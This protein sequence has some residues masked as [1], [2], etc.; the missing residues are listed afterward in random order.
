M[1]SFNKLSLIIILF[2]NV[3]CF[4]TV[5]SIIT[6]N[7]PDQQLLDSWLNAVKNDNKELARMLIGL[8][9]IG[10]I[11]KKDFDSK[12]KSNPML[13]LAIE[14]RLDHIVK[15]LSQVS[16]HEVNVLK[17]GFQVASI[18][19]SALGFHK[20]TAF[21][22]ENDF[23]EINAFLENETMLMCASQFGHENIVKFLL[24]VPGININVQNKRGETALSIAIAEQNSAVEKLIKDKV[25]ELLNL[26]FDAINQDNIQILRAIIAQIGIKNT[27]E[28]GDTLLHMA[29]KHKRLEIVRFI[30]LSDLTLLETNNKE[31]KDAIELSVGYPEVF[32]LIM[33]LV[34]AKHPCLNPAHHNLS[35][36]MPKA[37]PD[38]AKGLLKQAAQEKICANCTKICT[39]LCSQCKKIYY[40]STDCQKAHWTIHKKDC[41]N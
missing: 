21:L 32:E 38:A 33:S 31:G 3:G 39:Q 8:G 5:A 28:N 18:F 20:I 23:V 19:A 35:S 25:N 16:A 12:L 4:Q 41:Q 13:M 30:L 15:L 7:E 2:S 29:I 34:P 9:D 17:K 36:D 26:A 27:D 22:I 14:K 11:S 1:A 40:C 10:T 6:I 24:E 37:I